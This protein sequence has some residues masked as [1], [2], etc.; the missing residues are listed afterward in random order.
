MDQPQPKLCLPGA[1]LRQ[2]VTQR[3]TE[4]KMNWITAKCCS[5][6]IEF[7]SDDLGYSIQTTNNCVMTKF[8]IGINGERPIYKIIRKRAGVNTWH[9]YAGEE[10]DDRICTITCSMLMNFDLYFYEK[11]YPKRNE[12]TD[13]S[14]LESK[15]ESKDG[16][17]K[18]LQ[19]LD[20]A[21]GELMMM[22]NV[23][24]CA[25]NI[26]VEPNVD[27][28]LMMIINMIWVAIMNQ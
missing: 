28:V 11:P 1:D 19:I 26:C 13:F 21:S 10:L 4:A 15:I 7:D 3:Q 2:R 27:F 12:D 5:A 24:C 6:A 8:T 22:S 23:A 14:H 25:L 16:W 18:R 9:V 20:K 17:M